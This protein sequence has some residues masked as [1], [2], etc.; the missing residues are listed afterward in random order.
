MHVIITSSRRRAINL[1][2][3]EEWEGG[4]GVDG[5]IYF[6]VGV[7]PVGVNERLE[8]IRVLVGSIERGRVI[9]C[10]NCVQDRRDRRTRKVG[11]TFQ[12][13]LNDLQI[14]LWHPAFRDKCLEKIFLISSSPAQ[15]RGLLI[16][17]S[18]YLLCNI[19]TEQIETMVDGFDFPHLGEPLFQ[20]LGARHDE[21]CPVFLRLLQDGVEVLE[22]GVDAV[23]DFSPLTCPLWARIGC[24]VVALADLLDPGLQL[25]TLEEDHEH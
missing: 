11:A 17:F 8:T 12:R 16:G 7:N 23:H 18:S 4:D 10:G 5:R 22:P 3:K 2:C 14:V 25:L 15:I 21:P 6:P 19:K 20:A 9:S 24:G 1:T 13:L